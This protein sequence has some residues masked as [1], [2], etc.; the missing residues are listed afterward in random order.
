MNKIFVSAASAAVALTALCSAPS[1]SA[2]IDLDYN[3]DGVIN[4]LDMS[5]ARRVTTDKA[6]LE[7]L[8]NFLLDNEPSGS[9]IDVSCILEPKGTVH[10]GEGT[11][12]GGGY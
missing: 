9:P 3:G 12:Y 11:F 10:T 5:V 1:F 6:E 2:G 4:S 7:R 8:Q